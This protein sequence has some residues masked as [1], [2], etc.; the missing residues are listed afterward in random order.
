VGFGWARNETC[1]R[2]ESC[3][4]TTNTSMLS[5][6]HAI[7]WDVWHLQ[8]YQPMPCQIASSDALRLACI[9]CITL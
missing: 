8:L 3:N 9:H 1:K 7:A 2:K 6:V 4:F 5:V